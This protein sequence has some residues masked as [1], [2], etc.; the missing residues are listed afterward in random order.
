MITEKQGNHEKW[1]CARTCIPVDKQ[2]PG[3]YP[4]ACC[5]KSSRAV[6]T[7]RQG[8]PVDQGSPDW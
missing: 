5:H 3:E 2:S 8:M 6:L 7:D 4:G 1:P